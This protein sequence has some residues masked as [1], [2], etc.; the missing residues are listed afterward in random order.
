MMHLWGSASFTGEV[1]PN[2]ELKNMLST[3]AKDF[4]WEKL[5]QNLSDIEEL[6]FKSLDFYDKFQ[7]VAKNIERFLKKFTFIF[8]R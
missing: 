5:A 8:S 3:N 7:W 1:L 6:F 2:Y 4:S